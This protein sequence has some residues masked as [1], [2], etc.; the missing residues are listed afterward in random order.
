MR[1]SPRA[2]VGDGEAAPPGWAAPP[3]LQVEKRP[4]RRGD[5]SLGRP[6]GRLQQSSPGWGPLDKRL[7]PSRTHNRD[8]L[9]L[10]LSQRWRA[11]GR[12][13]TGRSRRWR[14]GG[15][16]RA[17]ARVVAPEEW[18]PGP[19]SVPIRQ[20]GAVCRRDQGRGW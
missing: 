18:R 2:G 10:K 14:V 5:S 1:D 8:R 11:G 17:G 15:S 6:Q 16:S 12:L 7:L 9:L 13:L 20:K 19:E 4:Q 3:E